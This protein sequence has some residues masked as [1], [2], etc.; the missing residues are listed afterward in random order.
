LGF[1]IDFNQGILLDFFQL[2]R[3]DLEE[4]GEVLIMADGDQSVP[5]FAP[6]QEP[7]IVVMGPKERAALFGR[8]ESPIDSEGFTDPIPKIKIAGR[9]ELLTSGLVFIF[10]RS[11]PGGAG[12]KPQGVPIL[13][14]RVWQ[15]ILIRYQWR[16]FFLA[17]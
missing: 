7:E 11:G 17:I 3:I 1:Q 13:P 14:I 5:S 15:G 16:G 6:A 10:L 2:F 8:M 4:I 9:K 12:R